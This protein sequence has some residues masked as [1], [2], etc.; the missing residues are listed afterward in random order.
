MAVEPE[1]LS[2]GAARL[3]ITPPAGLAMTGFAA[4]R[5]PAAGPHDPLEVRALVIGD[6]GLVIADV[7]GLDEALCARARTRSRLPDD[8]IVIAAT[9]THGGPAVMPGRLGGVVDGAY[10][11]RL[12]DAL[13]AALDQAAAARRPARLGFGLG[14][15]PDIARNR[16]H[17]G[18]PT[19]TSL[20]VLRV[21]AADGSTIA[22]LVAYACHPTVLGADNHLW[23]ADYPGQVRAKLD[24]VHPGAVTLFATGCAGDA[25]IGHSAHAS[26]RLGADPARS[27]ANAR[28]I[29]ETIAAAASRA[30]TGS[31]GSVVAARDG[32]VDLALARTEDRPLPDLAARWRSDAAGQDPGTAAV[33]DV[34]A[35]WADAAGTMPLTPWTARVTAL[36]WGGLRLLALPGEPFAATAHDIRKRLGTD[37]PTV[38]LGYGEGCPGYIPPAPEYAHAGYEV[39]EAHRYYGMPAAFAPGSAEALAD[40]AVDLA[41]S[42][43]EGA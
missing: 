6:T 23:T 24:A 25:N 10:R 27:F 18:G 41:N 42:V 37:R 17:P 21:V 39:A 40:L 8:R 16:R 22:V 29:G 9:H 2:A 5:S 32:T 26:F 20:P 12:E 19:D 11:Q 35:R 7:I 34:W 28:R 38:I 33:L 4:R 43:G 30:P 36:N 1:W 31:L 13:V 3:D 14:T 15:D